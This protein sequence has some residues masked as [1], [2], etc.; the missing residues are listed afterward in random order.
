M[1]N[2]SDQSI[3]DFSVLVD[4]IVFGWFD[5][6]TCP[7][8]GDRLKSKREVY[9]TVQDEVC[10]YACTVCDSIVEEPNPGEILF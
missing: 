4:A 6:C 1:I 3:E 8:C 5:T 10:V 7:N 9:Q 2:Q